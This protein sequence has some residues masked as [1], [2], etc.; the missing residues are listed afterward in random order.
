MDASG[1]TDE[2]APC[3]RRSRVV[4]TPRRWRQVGESNFANDGGKQARSPRRAR[5]KPL[6]PSRAGMPGDPGATV[7]TNARAIYS[8]RAAAGA[9]GTRHSPLP[10]RG[11]KFKHHSGATR[12]GNA[13]AYRFEVIPDSIFFRHSPMR[14]CAS[15]DAPSWRR[16]GI[17]TPRRGY[18]FR[19]RSQELAP[20][21]DG[22]LFVGC[23]KIESRISTGTQCVPRMPRSPQRCIFAE[24]I[25]TVAGRLATINLLPIHRRTTDAL[26]FSVQPRHKPAARTSSPCE[27]PFAK[28]WLRPLR[29]ELAICDSW[30][31]C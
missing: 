4:L 31:H 1:A 17:H 20:R 5:R 18:G 28:Q 26:L 14:N 6:K 27:H 21:N 16:P 23:L 9:T 24:K 7:V 11:A 10:Q 12:R 2:S 3:G 15:E 13:K 29:E 8:T 30:V 22:L 25:S 19:A